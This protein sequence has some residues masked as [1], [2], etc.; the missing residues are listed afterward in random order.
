VR[1]AGARTL[2]KT[3][4]PKRCKFFIWLSLHS[5]LSGRQVD[6][7]PAAAMCIQH[8]G[9]VPDFACWWFPVFSPDARRTMAGLLV[10]S[11]TEA[12]PKRSEERLRC[13]GCPRHL[14]SLEGENPAGLRPCFGSGAAA[15][16]GDFR[17]S[18]LASSRF[19]GSGRVVR[20]LVALLFSPLFR[21]CA[22]ARP[23]L[24]LCLVF[25]FHSS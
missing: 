7:S 23:S 24:A 14:A 21:V 22:R 19:S 16:R 3:R 12:G 4:A 17:R 20:C 25:L 18:Y 15:C 13:H 9:L 1:P 2:A 8:E 6:V 10:A 5:L 11:A